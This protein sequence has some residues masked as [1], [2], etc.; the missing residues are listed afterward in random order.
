MKVAIV[1]AGFAGISTAKYLQQYG[2][3]VTV[4]EACD[5]LGG[6]WSKARRYPG[7]ATQN[8]KETYS[9][10]DM[11]MPRHYPTWPAAQQVQ[12]YLDA[13]T[14]KHNL[15]RLM[16]FGTRV[17][18]AHPTQH[19]WEITTKKGT[20]TQS[21]HFEHLV[22]ATGTFS[23]GKIPDY[24]GIDEFKAAGGHICHSSDLGLDPKT[25]QDKNVLVVGYGKSSCDVANAVSASANSTTLVA[26]RLIWKLP[27]MIRG[28]PYQ[29]LLLTRLG[30]SLFEY[31]T[32]SAFEKWFN[33]GS[34]RMIR[35][36]MLNSLQWVVTG[37]LK[38]D[39]LG[40]VPEGPFEEIAR[41]TISLS[42]EGLYKNIEAGKVC[43]KRDAEIE[44]LTKDASGRPVAVLKDGST[45]ACDLLICA[46][47]FHQNVPFLPVDIQ[48]KFLDQNDNFLL[49]KHILPIGVPNLTFNGYNSSLFCPTS[50]EAAALW[51]SAHLAGL[52]HLPP[53][54]EMLQAA[55]QKLA[56]LDARSNGKH[57]HGTNLVP[58]SLHSID[59]TLKDVDLGLGT[60]ATIRQWL[61]P[62][63]P[64]DYA[65][66]GA[67]LGKRIHEANAAKLKH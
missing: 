27:R 5:D 56:W 3:D 54:D 16:Q 60:C 63:R 65:G 26:R 6:V 23:R 59:D 53:E 44:L 1:G 9:L 21:H 33:S 40:L 31:I 4:F 29:Y 22:V 51:I 15:R 32:P 45:L 58:F 36:A 25:V 10:S 62:V 46:T 42:T 50:S 57:A 34:G 14:D 30:E 20:T 64:R 67:R 41:S 13:Y 37:Q 43:V 7:L 48:K 35:N 19:G 28:I 2:H 24:K 38:L 8:S 49:H 12:D 66:L 61:L 52:T 55:K 17:E 11:D 18:R 39:H 47:G